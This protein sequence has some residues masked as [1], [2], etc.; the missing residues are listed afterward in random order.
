MFLHLS[1]IL[2]TWGVSYTP[3]QT[4]LP[5]DGH[6]GG[7][8]AS[9]WNALLLLKGEYLEEEQKEVA[10]FLKFILREVQEN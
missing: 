1:V 5:R 4:P 3:G 8:Y 9:Y 2:S 6:C 10:I 7:R